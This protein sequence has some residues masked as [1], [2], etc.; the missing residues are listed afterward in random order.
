MKKSQ[1]QTRATKCRKV[2]SPEGKED[3]VMKP[4]K[5]PRKLKATSDT[6]GP[7]QLGCADMENSREMNLSEYWLETEIQEEEPVVGVANLQLPTS[8]PSLKYVSEPSDEED[9][10][11]IHETL[12]PKGTV[13]PYKRRMKMMSERE[14]DECAKH[15][16][17]LRWSSD[18]E[19]DD[20]PILQMMNSKTGVEKEIIPDGQA[21]VGAGI[22]RFFGSDLGVFKDGRVKT[23]NASIM[24]LRIQGRP[25]LIILNIQRPCTHH[26]ACT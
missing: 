22:A 13:I 19:G 3:K 20:V 10:R 4:Y 1:W 15:G 14:A 24:S 25:L 21:A 8:P 2:M 7:T 23:L 5:K 18:S 17:V 9:L 6:E 26:S 12:K 16:E 11:P